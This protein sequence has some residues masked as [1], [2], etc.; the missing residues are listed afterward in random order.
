M[1]K[2]KNKEYR[3]PYWGP[4]V[5]ETTIEDEFVKILLEKGREATIDA[6]LDLAGQIEKEFY[7]EKYEDWFISRFSPYVDLYLENVVPYKG[8][9][10]QY[11]L[12]RNYS[13]MQEPWNSFQEINI[14]NITWFLH[15]LWINFQ[16]ANEYNPPHD[17]T[18]DL[19]FIIY[20][21]VPK[22]I[23]EEKS[24]QSSGG[25]VAPG[26]LCME[27]GIEMPFSIAGYS[28]VPEV[29]DILIFPAWLKHHV[30]AFKSDVERI[31][32]SGNMSL[33]LRNDKV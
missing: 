16:A 14:K 29:G 32:V 11:L 26:A 8:N 24:I 22:E 33:G 3:F 27:F 30:I 28:K 23:G 25:T 7:Y 31:S 19:S 20:L 17:H 6:R 18:G 12:E 4:F 1:I 21:Q 13:T 2:F 9:S 10:F 15:A 5:L